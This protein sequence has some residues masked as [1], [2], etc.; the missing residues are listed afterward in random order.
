M[1][2]HL[3]PSVHDGRS[4]DPFADPLTAARSMAA[5]GWVVFPCDHPD[6]DPA[7][8]TGSSRR[9]RSGRCEASANP[10]KR[11]KHPRCAW[12]SVVAPADDDQLRRWFDG[13]LPANVAVAAGPSHLVIIDEDKDGALAAYAESVGEAVPQTF[14]VRSYRGSHHYFAEPLDDEGER[15][16]LGN[17]AGVLTA[18][19]M[20]VRG[21]AS[22]R[23]AG[24]GY[25][26]GPGSVHWSGTP[27]AVEHDVTPLA[28]PG[29]LTEAINMEPPGPAEGTVP[30]RAGDE[31]RATGVTRPGRDERYARE[32]PRPPSTAA[33]LRDTYHTW[34]EQAANATGGGDWREHLHTA[35]LGGWR[36]VALGLLTEDELLRDLDGAAQYVWGADLDDDD[37][38]IVF[39]EAA[40]HAQA[41]PWTLTAAETLR[42][43]REARA[44]AGQ[45]TEA[46][47]RP[48]LPDDGGAG[49]ASPG[50][51][52]A[53]QRAYGCTTQGKQTVDPDHAAESS[54][55]AD[56]IELADRAVRDAQ[57]AVED[58]HARKVRERVEWL[59]VNAEAARERAERDVVTIE[60][61]DAVIFFGG[62]PPDYLVPGMIYR[63][64]LTVMFGQP[65]SGKSW[66][67][68]DIC[69]SFTTGKP[70]A[71]GDGIVI[72]LPDGA[73]GVAHYV[74]AEAPGT[75]RGRGNAWLQYHGVPVEGIRER[76]IPIMEPF[77][78]T[79]AGVA[80]YL[81]L[82]VR[83]KPN[84]IVLDTKNAMYDGKESQGEDVAEMVRV[85]RAI[86]D[87]AGGCTIIL[88]D[89]SGLNAPRRVRG[90]NALEGATDSMVMV[91]KIKEG[92]R[93]HRAEVLRDKNAP[94][95]GVE[96]TF[97]RETVIVKGRAEA[98]LLPATVDGHRPVTVG[99]SWWDD[100]L[101]DAI[102]EIIDAAREKLANG[103]SSAAKGK[104]EAK[105]IMQLL[106][107]M[108][109]EAPVQA[110][111]R[112]MIN[113][114]RTHP[115]DHL[116][117]WA[118]S[119][120]CG[121]LVAEGLVDDV[122][123]AAA[124]RY[125]VVDRYSK[126]EMPE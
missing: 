90:S 95:E 73:P 98:V 44:A 1:M 9:C 65:G 40:P 71:I 46:P 52:E 80:A 124:Q 112:R 6:A 58:D 77:K 107:A 20:D 19:G 67:A 63:D 106:R 70:W 117:E 93:A 15:V 79:E 72:A 119:R 75:N 56:V 17:S 27:Y 85:L 8:C 50:Q 32:D 92:D 35:A 25:V 26:I 60:S 113:E 36:L 123:T 111:I 51:A 22:D 97:R 88:I 108:T 74:M 18:A 37:H 104:R 76:F 69:L 23:H 62:D 39:E 81:P 126:H 10:Q 30:G 5:R 21:G 13:R 125:V 121:L 53:W 91:E 66:L 24:G 33:A 105:V 118:V 99:G 4:P 122:G 68:L 87:A 29:W 116:K 115:D 12:G 54:Q 89:H 84:L 94:D 78:L 55:V 120:G 14:R 45:D 96:W 42:L 3:P 41:D 49:F 47:A 11:G 61:E 100:V 64:G 101:P 7:R 109:G 28:L 57:T 16:P 31:G 102:R 82:V 48:G 83:D 38:V 103:G 2:A 114:T 34:G 43:A 86:R 110:K 59:D